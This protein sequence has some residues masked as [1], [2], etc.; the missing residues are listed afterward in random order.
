MPE[1][2]R[3]DEGAVLVAGEH[4]NELL[5]ALV[6]PDA[7]EISSQPSAGG[8]PRVNLRMAGVGASATGHVDAA[9]IDVLASATAMRAA[10][11]GGALRWSLEAAL[12]YAGERQAFGR[13]IAKFQAI[14][15]HLAQ[16][17]GEVCATEVAAAVALQALDRGTARMEA[18]AAKI[19][20]DEAASDGSIIAHQVFGAIGFTDEHVLHR[21]TTR[22]LSWRDDFGSGSEW[23]AYLGRMVAK[24]GSD[25]FWPAITSDRIEATGV[26]P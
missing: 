20:A 3:G 6:A 22:M 7:C 25:G 1:R 4:D 5:F 17:A 12:T 26:S 9:L 24:T 13:P 21:Y 2:F 15:H 8:I 18:A 16:L 11:I 14:Q 10:Q 19:R 23:A